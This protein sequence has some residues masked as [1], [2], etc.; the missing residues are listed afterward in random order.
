[1][2]FEGLSQFLSPKEVNQLMNYHKFPLK[3]KDKLPFMKVLVEDPVYLTR[4]GDKFVDTLENVELMRRWEKSEGYSDDVAILRKANKFR[5]Q[6]LDS[7]YGQFLDY[8]KKNLAHD[9]ILVVT[10]DH[11]EGSGEHGYLAHSGDPNDEKLH[12]FFAV[13]F[14]G[15]SKQ[16]IFDQ[17]FS[18]KQQAKIFESFI[19]RKLNE[20]N[21]SK[22]IQSFNTDEI[23]VSYG[24]VGDVASARQSNK[25]KLIYNFKSDS[26]LLYDLQS[27]PR[28]LRNIASLNYDIKVKLKKAIDDN[29]VKQK[30][31]DGRCINW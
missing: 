8:Y 22:Y 23:L 15:Q 11:G 26:Y 20:S 6:M 3:Y 30:V 28:E 7:F 10:G 24:C 2:S 13:H 17:Q 29:L 9:T 4:D 25:W 16:I 21:F 12:F 19:F 27:D 14:P 1:M 5:L 18:Q 31:S